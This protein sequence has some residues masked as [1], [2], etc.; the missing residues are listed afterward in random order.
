LPSDRLLLACLFGPGMDLGEDMW[1]W[2]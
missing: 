1:L 2:W